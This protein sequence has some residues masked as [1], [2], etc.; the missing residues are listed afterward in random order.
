[1]DHQ[2][3]KG[4]DISLSKL[5]DFSP[6][7]TLDRKSI[8]EVIKER[9]EEFGQYLWNSHSSGAGGIDL[10]R[11]NAQFFDSL[12]CFLF[13]T[14][15]R[16]YY[17]K[18][19]KLEFPVAILA[20][21]G[22]GRMDLC[23]QSDIDL[24][25]LYHYKLNPFVEAVTEEMLYSMW[26][27]GLTVGH[28]VRNVKEALSYAAEDS[29]IR[30]ALMDYRFVCGNYPFLER[31]KSTL[32]RFLL[33][34]SGDKFIEERIRDLRRRH[35]KFGGV[36]YL[37]E[38]NIKEGKGGLRDL[39]TIL[40]TLKV[41]FKAVTLRELVTK[42]VLSP[43]SEKNLYYILD[44][45]LRIRNHI[46]FITGRKTDVIN[47]EL[48]EN[49]AEFWGYRK[50]GIFLGT[51][52]FMRFYYILAT[53]CSQLTEEIV[54]EVEKFLP[55]REKK[56]FY[57]PFKKR[58]SDGN[59]STYNG[60]LYVNSSLSFI[61]SPELI[62]K[63]FSY[64]Q[65]SG[66]PLSSQAKRRIKKV[67]NIVDSRFR[68]NRDVANEFLD[69]FKR[70]KDLGRVLMEMNECRF[71]GKYIPEFSHLFFRV[72]QDIYHRFTVDIHSIMSASVMTEIGERVRKNES[73]SDEERHFFDIYSKIR[74]KPLFLLSVLFH[75]IG[76]GLGHGHS[77]IGESL[78]EGILK[79]FGM[80]NEEIE[81]YKFLVRNHLEMANISQ[82]RDM[83]DIE[84]I[85]NFAMKVGS[86]NRLEMLYLLTYCDLKSVSEDSWNQW[87][88]MLIRELYEKA[89]NILE[90]GEFKLS[91][92]HEFLSARM[93]NIRSMLD[94]F[95]EERVEHFLQS[96]PDRYFL[97]TPEDRF[98]EHYN[99][100]VSYKGEPLIDVKNYLDKR[101]SEITVVCRDSHG[102]F[103]KITGVIAAHNVNIL[104][105]NV[106]TS[107]GDVALDSFQ[108]N[109]L[110]GAFRD[111]NKVEKLTG[112][113][114]SVIRKDLDVEALMATRGTERAR[115]G[116]IVKYRPT[117]VQIDNETSRNFTIVDIFTYDRVGLLYDITKTI[118]S[119]GYEI[120]LSKISTKADQVADVFHICDPPSKKIDDPEKVEEL[121][122]AIYEAIE[123]GV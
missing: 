75:D 98:Y 82:R 45:L 10:V 74:K 19:P 79:R 28:A 106:T 72:Q 112:D 108:I 5:N 110:G 16:S 56:K 68:W 7:L 115:D 88:S 63:I 1:M 40:W 20:V 47:F 54:E 64:S 58:I 100:F 13:E 48:Q 121:R 65:E 102:L 71:L 52:R 11:V 120:Y 105:A 23:P 8:K 17:K 37:L 101:Y 92:F 103:S 76:K 14:S 122:D 31:S 62:M 41:K 70:G 99:L 18:Y 94:E 24:L 55:E 33:Y 123:E 119:L 86:V 93:D 118:S 91:P 29:S 116:K 59:F 12:I 104:G 113:L 50:H 117:R 80:G 61:R 6:F 69:I 22:Y 73:L 77:K 46:H 2:V 30:T 39:H 87:R 44:N 90:Q 109:Y 35:K 85:H 96:L 9:R 111:A 67:L 60:K 97:S 36:V 81:D 66:N 95:D 49:L 84:M 32:D 114:I 15:K 78:G 43:R 42:G 89:R 26:D 107:K 34:S 25:F 83:H 21:G 3:N 27:I 53:L 51:E 57:L 4:T 38:P